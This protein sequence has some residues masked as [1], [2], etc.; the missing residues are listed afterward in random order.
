[1]LPEVILHA[2]GLL[3]FG[4]INILTNIE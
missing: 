4:M 3:L 1:M 2:A